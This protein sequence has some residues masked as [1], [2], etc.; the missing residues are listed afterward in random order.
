M[1]TIDLPRQMIYLKSNILPLTGLS[2][3]DIIGLC[4]L[5]G[6]NAVIYG[7][8][9][10]YASRNTLTLGPSNVP[11]NDIDIL[12]NDVTT[13]DKIIILLKKSLPN[14]NY[15]LVKISGAPMWYNTNN[16]TATRI[17]STDLEI[18]SIASD[19][20]IGYVSLIDYNKNLDQINVDLSISKNQFLSYGVSSSSGPNAN[21]SM[22]MLT[23]STISNSNN[24]KANIINNYTGDVQPIKNIFIKKGC[25]PIQIQLKTQISGY[26]S[27]YILNE[28][29]FI[30]ASGTFNG[31]A[32]IVPSEI[33][34]NITIL[35]E[36]F[37][38]TKFDWLIYRIDKYIKRG[39]TI[40]LDNQT[41]VEQWNTNILNNYNKNFNTGSPLT[42]AMTCPFRLKTDPLYNTLKDNPP[43]PPIFVNNFIIPI[44][45]NPTNM[46][47]SA[48]FINIYAALKD[49][50][51]NAYP[52]TNP[53]INNHY[54][55]LNNS[56][57]LTPNTLVN[58]ISTQL[59]NSEQAYNTNIIPKSIG[60]NILLP[61]DANSRLAELN[62]SGIVTGYIYR[63]NNNQISIDNINWI[64]YNDSFIYS[65]GIT[66]K[67]IGIGIGVPIILEVNLP[68]ILNSVVP[69]LKSTILPLTSLSD[70]N[71]TSLCNLLGKHAVI[72]GSS[73]LY[74]SRKTLT[75]GTTNDPINDIDIL[76]DDS[77]VYDN[78][79]GLLSSY[80]SEYDLL[81]LNEKS[82]DVPINNLRQQYFVTSSKKP[83]ND[84][85]MGLFNVDKATSSTISGSFISKINDQLFKK[86]KLYYK[87]NNHIQIQV[88][89]IQSVDNCLSYYILNNSDFTCASGSFDGTN[90][91]ISQESLSNITIFRES[92]AKKLDWLIYRLDKYIKRGFIIFF[93]NQKQQDKWDLYMLNYSNKFSSS[94]LTEPMTCPFRLKS[95]PLYITLTT[96][97]SVPSIL[98][99]NITKSFTDPTQIN[100]YFLNIDIVLKNNI[101]SA[102]PVVNPVV[103][104]YYNTLNNSNYFTPSTVVNYISTQLIN[105]EQGYS[106]NI[107][108]TSVG[109]N[110]LLPLNSNSKLAQINASGI[111]TGYIYRNNNNQISIDNN[112][113][114]SYNETFTYSSGVTAKLIG[115]G[116]PVILT[117][118]QQTIP[119]L[120]K[121]TLVL[122]P[123]GFIK[124]EDLE[125]GQLITTH[126]GTSERII[127]IFHKH[128]I[129]SEDP[130]IDVK[131]YK[132]DGQ[133]PL[134]ISYWHKMLRSNGLLY[135]GYLQLPLATKEE[136]CGSDDMFEL[137][138]IQLNDSCNNHLVVN[139][140]IVVESWSGI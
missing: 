131:M 38:N 25:L 2:D 23:I 77:D 72:Y 70:S 35:R 34:S 79:C 126:N 116:S 99:D 42:K 36:G 111:V 19:T 13:Y 93:D 86:K 109:T 125:E 63:N 51:S 139:H 81:N 133:N 129:W 54:N 83:M 30:C 121:G 28:A 74:A 10:L 59:I 138:H 61:L 108:P 3:T 64:S 118:V 137:Y 37:P 40:F 85:P 33:S 100:T 11:I 50:I 58:Y 132:V 15:E 78:I 68:I 57:Y 65:P 60:T 107:I 52:V 71:I 26:V 43:S 98:L 7:S 124:I 106:S 134:Y 24:I 140:G 110:I 17:L 27:S 84:S 136:L 103:N 1:S 135:A 20:I 69:Y 92:L 114:I 113:W 75:L 105:S 67:L 18:R 8:S 5:L 9:I 22:G 128:V 56:D 94:V 41:Q 6:K 55:S 130:F 117:F 49:Q 87:D 14:C 44:V 53:V 123:Y 97:P 76:I 101:S 115:I 45:Q 46:Q 73:I 47:I 95:D 90:L 21:E 89:L 29:D 31:S 39:F 12:V 120:L 102:S 80:L 66:A 91:F 32:L 119:C 82:K 88:Q 4:S 127:K 62:A 48:Y 16:L 122:T 104:N 112:K 96:N